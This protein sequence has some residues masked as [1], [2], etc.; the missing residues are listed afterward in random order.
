[1]EYDARMEM[2][3]SN[4]HSKNSSS[5]SKTPHNCA[6]ILY[7]VVS[8]GGEQ[9]CAWCCSSPWIIP[10]VYNSIIV[11]WSEL[12]CIRILSKN[13]QFSLNRL[14]MGIGPRPKFQCA[15]SLLSVWRDPTS[16]N[17][18]CWSSAVG[19][20]SGYLESDR[21][22]KVVDSGSVRLVIERNFSYSGKFL[23]RFLQLRK[24]TFMSLHNFGG[25]YKTCHTSYNSLWWLLIISRC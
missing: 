12:S 13:M 11:P 9:C 14:L 16:A 23:E 10:T 2:K 19:S 6:F 5:I 17:I 7:F 21:S 3:T 15:W 18:R 8:I 22:G 20:R 24:Y 1:M 4:G 25:F